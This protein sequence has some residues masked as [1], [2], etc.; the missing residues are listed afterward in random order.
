MCLESRRS[1]NVR[2][3]TPIVVPRRDAGRDVISMPHKWSVTWNLV[4]PLRQN[5]TPVYIPYMATSTQQYVC[6]T[7]VPPSRRCICTHSQSQKRAGSKIHGIYWV[8]AHL[9][10][11]REIVHVAR[12]VPTRVREGLDIPAKPCRTVDTQCRQS[13]DPMTRTLPCVAS[14]HPN[15]PPSTCPN[16][17]IFLPV[18]ECS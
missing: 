5:I 14:N 9:P 15:W 18:A 7:V 13:F 10:R 8:G 12:I 2:E 3:N 6:L 4:S 1:M 11:N 17:E 16:L